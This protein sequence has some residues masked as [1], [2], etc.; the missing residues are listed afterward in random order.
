M[1]KN[2]TQK[3]GINA[4]CP[5][6]GDRHLDRTQNWAT[7]LA[8]ASLV[9]VGMIP[10]PALAA[11]PMVVERCDT[12]STYTS[13]AAYANS[14]V[15]KYAAGAGQLLVISRSEKTSFIFN[16]NV[17]ANRY[18]VPF[19]GLWWTNYTYSVNPTTT[20]PTNDLGALQ[21]D[22]EIFKGMRAS[23]LQLKSLPPDLNGIQYNSYADP[24]K[25]GIGISRDI[26]TQVGLNKVYTNPN[27][28]GVA[29]PYIIVINAL[30]G[31]VY[32]I[33][34]GQ[35]IEFKFA[36]GGVIN[37]KV[38]VM[39]STS[40]GFYVGV[41]KIVVGA[42]A[43]YTTGPNAPSGSTSVPSWNTGTSDMTGTPIIV[44]VV[45]N[46]TTG[47]AIITIG[48]PIEVNSYSTPTTYYYYGY[49]TN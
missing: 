23:G 11:V 48:E 49:E 34:D 8:V 1:K 9:A 19:P 28:P 18:Y 37:L 30:D 7:P 2:R 16:Y 29:L 35:Q 26:L 20:F 36:D 38:F 47:T 22:M 42:N 6:I 4:H 25:M 13:L 5:T 41:T 32:P 27:F 46:P 14:A 15:T 39:K 17:V 33:F 24:N 40:K 31:K 3:P 43:K 44:A 21:Q 10:F 45:P 12:C